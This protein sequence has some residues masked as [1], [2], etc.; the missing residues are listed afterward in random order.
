MIAAGSLLEFAF[1]EEQFSFPVGRVQFL[2]LK[3]LS[4]YE[5]LISQKHD[6]LVELLDN[7]TLQQPFDTFIHE[8]LLQILREYF[9]IGG[10]P[11][12]VNCFLETNLFLECQIIL[13][14]LLE[15]YRSDFSK[16][17]RK[18]QYKY[19]QIFFEKAPG[20]ISNHFKYSHVSSEHRSNA[21]FA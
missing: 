4:F 18:A 5:Y 11:S 19:L 15:T 8:Q 7:V 9:L 13:T 17:A 16:Y 20:L 6:R 12:V 21:I 3:P 2:Y 14:S 1:H 10:M